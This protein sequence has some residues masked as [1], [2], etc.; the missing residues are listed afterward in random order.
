MSRTGL[1]DKPR[2]AESKAVNLLRV[3]AI[4]FGPLG[5]GRGL[6]GMRRMAATAMVEVVEP[7][8]EGPR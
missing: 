4:G 6:A 8:N 5:Q 1:G 7:G 3:C 2:V